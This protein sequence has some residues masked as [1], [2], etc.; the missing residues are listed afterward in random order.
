[1]VESTRGSTP[2]NSVP[3]EFLRESEAARSGPAARMTDA[4]W[5]TSGEP[6]HSMHKNNPW[7]VRIGDPKSQGG[8]DSRNAD[9]YYEFV[10]RAHRVPTDVV[11]IFLPPS[12]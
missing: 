9:E 10:K 8:R 4:Q 12:I 3:T 7:L 11:R 5:F 1:M 2:D 6:F